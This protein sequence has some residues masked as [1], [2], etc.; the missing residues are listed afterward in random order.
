MNFN[1][2][3]TKVQPLYILEILKKHTNS[4]K[5]LTKE[6]IA[7]KLRDEGYCPVRKDKKGKYVERSIS[8]TKS[9]SNDLDMLLDLGFKIHGLEPEI[10]EETGREIQPRGKIW[11]EKDISDEKLQMLIDTIVFS[12]FIEKSEAKELIDALIL[13]GGN[14]SE[15]K[16]SGS[17]RIDGGQVYHQ[18]KAEFFKELKVINQAMGLKEPKKVAFKY[19]QYKYEN[20]KFILEKVREHIVSPY[21]FVIQKGYYYLIGYN[22]KKECLWHYRLDYVKDAKILKELAKPR[23]E[24]ELNG[25]DIGKYVLEH[26]YMFAGSPKGIEVRVSAERIGIIHDTFGTAFTKIKDN[27]D[28]I[29]FRVHCTEEDA[30]H[31]AMQYGSHIEVLKPQSLRDRIRYHVECMMFNYQSGEGDKY[32]EAIRFARR[33][34]VLN[35]EGVD[36]NGKTKHYSLKNVRKVRLSNNN[37]DNVDFLKNMP[38]LC[39]V[40]IK[41]NPIT[42]ISALKYCK[43]INTLQL[44]NLKISSIDAICDLPIYSLYLGLGRT[45]DLS[46]VT[47]LK[48][49]KFI[50]GTYECVYNNETLAYAWEELEKKG[51]RQQVTEKEGDDVNKNN[52]H[53]LNAYYPYNLM[54]VIFGRENIWV[55]EHDEIVSAMDKVVE[56]F[57]GKERQ[58]IELIYQQRVSDFTARKTLGL[59]E[60]EFWDIKK[61]VD[62]KLENRQYVG[63]LEKFVEEEDYQRNYSLADLRKRLTIIEKISKN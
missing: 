26:P 42:D 48:K 52:G 44:E 6:G 56:K 58:Y 35:L 7:E 21:H 49:L 46:A 39:E 5:F 61:V 50:K 32:T 30:F 14:E 54:R 63:S 8:E 24:T 23:R 13:L 3:G 1:M 19:A 9:I 55:G 31:W 2:N 4:G 40:S 16:K 22:H 20:D 47:K 45:E 27:G 12:N 15:S 51:V 59:S 53:F 60:E 37:I 62:K 17:S 10:D 57:V 34:K 11:I 25:K 41:N 38:F 33:H 18:E 28:T 43:N 36:L 29:D